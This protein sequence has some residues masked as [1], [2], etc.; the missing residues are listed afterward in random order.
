MTRYI[1]KVNQV[2]CVSIKGILIELSLL[3]WGL[4]IDPKIVKENIQRFYMDLLNLGQ[5]LARSR[6]FIALAFQNCFCCF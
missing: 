6:G 4:S 2:C 5:I 3:A 1:I